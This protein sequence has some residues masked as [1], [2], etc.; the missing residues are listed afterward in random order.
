MNIIFSQDIMEELTT[1]IIIT[2]CILAF[3]LHYE[4]KYSELIYVKSSVDDRSYLVR[5]LPDKQKAADLLGNVRK[6]LDT[7]ANYLKKN[8]NDKERVRRLEKNYRP[9]NLS[10]AIPKAN[11]TSY[12]VN[13]G[14]KIVFCIRSKNNKENLEDINTVMFVA[15]HEMAHVITKSVGHTSEFWNNMKFLLKKAIKLNV[16]KQHDYKNNPISYCGVE[17]TD[18]PLPYNK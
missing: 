9:D 6:N 10:E 17:I 18:S 5:N 12:S 11:Y 14:E 4:S 13:K 8:D 7:I 15:I 2:I 16:Y 1:I 3:F